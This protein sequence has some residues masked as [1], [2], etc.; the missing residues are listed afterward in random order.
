MREGDESIPLLSRK[1]ERTAAICSVPLTRKVLAEF[2]GTFMLLFIAAGSGITNEKN[3]GSLGAIGLAAASG[4]AVMMIILTTGHISGAHLN[5]AVTLAFATT[6]FFPWFQVP[7]YIAA[8][9][10]ASTCSSFCLKAIFHPSLSGG[11][12]VPSGN[13]VQALLTE[14]VLT[15]I[16]HFVNTAMGTDKRAV[17]QLGGLA[18]GATVAMNTLVGGPTTGASM[19]PARSLGPAIAANNFSGIWIY[20]VGP[21]PGALLGGLAYCLIRIREEE[22]SDGPPPSTTFFRRQRS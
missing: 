5:P 14:F 8:Q 13:I 19:N 15:A 7:F 17:G 20:F 4:F 21:I 1:M 2:F 12:T 3:G 6:G 18:V 10:I 22:V 11:V 16:L 9:L